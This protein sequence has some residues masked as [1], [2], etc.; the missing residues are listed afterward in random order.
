MKYIC[1]PL[2]SLLSI[3]LL[4]T[5][6]KTPKDV[7]YF[8]GI[9]QLTPAQEAAM[10][11]IHIPK[12]CVDDV[13]VINVTSP[14]GQSAAGYS[15]A[16]YVYNKP[17]ESDASLSETQ[18]LYTYLVDEEGYI[19]FPRLGR[20]QLAG[21][22]VNEANRKM[23]EL[24]MPAV[25]KVLVSVQIV[26]FKVG[27]IG[28][29][30][31]PDIYSINGTRVSILDLMA[32]AGDLKITGDRKNVL[33]MRDHNG[34]KEHAILDLTDP[35]IFTSPYYYL[36]QNDMV[37]VAPNKAQKKNA[38]YNEEKGFMA[39]LF[40]LILSGLTSVATIIVQTSK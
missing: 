12:I 6:C 29:V 34:V 16:P 5:S 38:K 35:A 3:L 25:P 7:V 39:S 17:G 15:V 27:I 13:L 9:D 30:K 2:L 24:I 26:N 23:E 8:Q 36:Q 4:A 19:K 11:Q 10:N 21:L 28:E 18:N 31:N 14:D 1:I 32:M 37:Y 33:L 40:A 20:V 22:T